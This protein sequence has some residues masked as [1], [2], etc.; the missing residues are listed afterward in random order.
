MIEVYKIR[1]GIEGVKERESFLPLSKHNSKAA[2]AD[3]H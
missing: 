1:H 2:N 3:G